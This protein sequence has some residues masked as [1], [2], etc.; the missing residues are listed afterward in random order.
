M[1][2]NLIIEILQPAR[3]VS[4]DKSCVGSL[5]EVLGL[6]DNL[7][8]TIPCLDG[9]LKL[10]E[11]SLLLIKL[12]KLLFWYINQAEFLICFSQKYSHYV[13]SQRAAIKICCGFF[14]FQT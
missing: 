14:T 10:A 2:I 6:D 13:G 11:D 1:T 12:L 7:M 3:K 5:F 4:N 8:L 9:I